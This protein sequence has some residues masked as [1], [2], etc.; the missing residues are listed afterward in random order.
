M[1]NI[2]PMSIRLATGSKVVLDLLY[3]VPIVFCGVGGHAINSMCPVGLSKTC[4]MI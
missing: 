3:I 1:D 4:N 2:E